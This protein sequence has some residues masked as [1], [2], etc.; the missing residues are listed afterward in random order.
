MKAGKTPSYKDLIDDATQTLF[1]TSDTPRIDA[2]VLM[3]HIIERPLAWLI[4]HGETIA[5][6]EHV[7]AFYRLITQRHSGHPIAYLV[8]HKDFWS[9][10]LKVDSN[11]LIPRADTETLIEKALERLPQ[12]TSLDVLDLGTGSGAIGLSI[13]KE[14]PLATVLA[15]DSQDN[16][17]AIA[18]ENALTNNINNAVFLLSDWY[19]GLPNEKQFDLIASNPPYIE[20][21]DEHLRKGDLRFEPSTALVASDNG[22]ADL[23]TIIF[24][25]PSYLK[26]HGWLL[27]EHGFNQA[28]EVAELFKASGFVDIECAKDINNLE[29][30]TL[31]RLA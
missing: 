12:E 11:V 20:A 7:K 9:L 1:D 29:R 16:A 4:A 2:E 30:C 24:K 3:Q 18:R 27:V 21:N 6:A 10:S 28:R 5:L 15:V 14:R 8:G 17:L 31:G 25:A 23:N 19:C 26:Q 22:L 13:A